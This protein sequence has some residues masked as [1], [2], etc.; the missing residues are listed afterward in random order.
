MAAAEAGRPAPM[1]GTVV[2]AGVG[3]IGGSVGL[4]IRQRFLADE[5]I[6]LD[7]DPTV[8]DA[9]RGLGVIDSAQLEPG[10]WLERADLVLLATP[11]KTIVPFANRI[12]PYLRPDTI[13][14]DVGSVK[15]E[16]VAGLRSLR[17][18]GGHPMA[19]SDRAGVLNADAALLETAVWVL[20]PDDS[21]DPDAL[22]SVKAFVTALGARPI[23]TSPEQHDRLVAVVS[24]LP[25][26]T[27][28]ALTTLV[29]EG[30][31]RDLKMLLAAGGF[32]DLT[33]VA[34]GSPLMSRDML[35]GNRDAV[36]EAV[37]GFRRQLELLEHQLDDDALLL[38]RAENAKRT[39]DAM[40]IVRRS[41]LPA[42][43]ELVIAVPDRSG[44]FARITRALGEAGVN[45]K[46]LEVLAVRETGGAIRIAVESEAA[47]AEAKR[48]LGQAGYEVRQRNGG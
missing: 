6:G 9:A 21:T 43:F 36:R 30:D 40:P 41:L 1:F 27:A 26:L 39:R 44:E 3:L 46:D 38:E 12:A 25:Y 20:T 13:V 23:H 28:V 7:R 11:A 14:T 32:R 4:G 33:R 24:H 42:R 10:S 2:L 34:S 31:E 17:F 18:V 15:R 37:R 19:G 8:L 16:V 35:A 22:A 48:A 45:I 47:L 29:E 5:V